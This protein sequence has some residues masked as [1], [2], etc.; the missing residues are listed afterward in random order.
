MLSVH[1]AR[2]SMSTHTPTPGV[3]VLWQMMM[4]IL[5]VITM[6]SKFM[7]RHTQ[8]IGKKKEKIF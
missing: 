8:H 1:H 7:P 3:N 4:M 2:L 6:T 5:H